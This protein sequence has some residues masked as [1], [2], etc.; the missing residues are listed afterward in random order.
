[1]TTAVSDIAVQFQSVHQ[2]GNALYFW[3]A[4]THVYFIFLARIVEPPS[5]QTHQTYCS[6]PIRIYSLPNYGFMQRSGEVNGN[7]C[8]DS[9]RNVF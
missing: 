9:S 1:M 7:S 3:F 2:P 5:K 8:L 4:N 6:I